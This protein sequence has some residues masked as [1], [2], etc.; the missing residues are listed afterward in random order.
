MDLSFDAALGVF[1]L[2][3][4]KWVLVIHI[5]GFLTWIGSLFALY[6]LL[7]AHQKAGEGARGAFVEM[8]KKTA[9]AMDIGAFVAMLGGF[10]YAIRGGTFSAGGWFHTKLLLAA[11]I[12]GFHGFARVK[13]RKFR[14]GDIKPIPT[15]FTPLMTLTVLGII[16]LVMV[17]PF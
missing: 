13:V 7:Y 17:R 4:Q 6:E 1:S 15:V 11:I 8:E 14:D 3:T 10:Y 2:T 12:I 16:I 9:L 5:F